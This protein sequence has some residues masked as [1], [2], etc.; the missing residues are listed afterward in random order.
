MVLRSYFFD[1]Y[2]LHEVLEGNPNYRN[3]TKDIG[4]I[5]TKLN[6]LEL[7]YD[8]LLKKGKAI[9]E[10][11]YDAF[12]NFTIDLDDDL[13][14]EA[15]FFRLEIKNRNPKSNISYIDALGYVAA[16]RNKIKFLTGDKEFENL[17]NVEYVK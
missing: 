17:D 13:I 9:A 12:Q 6:L 5:T 10:K 8:Y 15:M 2:A 4:I 1:T 14:K 3:F 16:K 7:Y 11:V